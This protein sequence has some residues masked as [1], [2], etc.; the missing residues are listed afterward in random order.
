MK[1]CVVTL[2]M[3]LLFVTALASCSDANKQ[4]DGTATPLKEQ[5]L[6]LWEFEKQME[7][8]NFSPCFYAIVDGALE[9][10]P[11]AAV[12]KCK[13][14]VA[15]L[16]KLSIPSGLPSKVSTDLEEAKAILQRNAAWSLKSAQFVAGEINSPAGFVPDN[17]QTCDA[18]SQ[19]D[20]VNKRYGLKALMKGQYINCEVLNSEKI[21]VFPTMNA[22]K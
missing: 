1:K 5:Q 7:C 15:G 22:V 3:M 18:Y 6:A 21:P 17:A 13:K 8:Q 4:A 16:S 14:A 19:I 9:R 11:V 10:D 12:E 2:F 20:K